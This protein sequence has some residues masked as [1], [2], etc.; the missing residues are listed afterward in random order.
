MQRR[1]GERET[2]SRS[3]RTENEERSVRREGKKKPPA[4]FPATLEKKMKLKKIFVVCTRKNSQTTWTCAAAACAFCDACACSSCACAS[5]ELSQRGK[6]GD[7]VGFAAAE[8]D[9]RGG[10]FR[11]RDASASASSAPGGEAAAARE[12][13]PN[14]TRTPPLPLSL[15]VVVSST[16]KCK[17]SVA[18]KRLWPGALLMLFSEEKRKKKRRGSVS[19][20]VEVE[21]SQVFDRLLSLFFF[22]SQ[23]HAT[24]FS[25]HQ[26][27]SLA[28]SRT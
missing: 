1:H 6:A 7:G 10:E 25:L 13:L 4:S 19:G 18:V 12:Q 28:S 27:S 24:P 23:E 22:S 15:A 21:M 20:K 3:R 5:G 17:P 14:S 8:E 9:G 26:F 16:A 11:P 2:D